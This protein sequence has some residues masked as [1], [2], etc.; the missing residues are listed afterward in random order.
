M[1]V[2]FNSVDSKLDCYGYLL[3]IFDDLL[4]LEIPYARECAE[5]VYPYVVLD[6]ITHAAKELVLDDDN[7]ENENGHSAT[8][9]AHADRD[10]VSRL[11]TPLTLV[12]A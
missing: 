2:D 1:I 8:P 12:R 5:V 9:V 3:D 11:G 10:E 6:M 4:R 7:D